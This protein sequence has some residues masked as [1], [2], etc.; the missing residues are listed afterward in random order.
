MLA[1]LSILLFLGAGVGCASTAP[2]PQTGVTGISSPGYWLARADASEARGDLAEAGRC[3]DRQVQEH[4][5]AADAELWRRRLGLALALGDVEA[6]RATRERLF[7]LAPEDEVLRLALAEDFASCERMVEA[8]AMLDHEFTDPLAQLRAWRLGAE[9]LEK[10]ELWR[11]AAELLERAAEH[12]AAGSSAGA[13]WERASWLRERAG[14]RAQAAVDLARALDG[15]E[16]GPREAAALSR[17][18]A[19]ELGEI[20][21]RVD[22]V[23]VLR[24]HTVAEHRLTAARFLAGQRFDDEI[25]V[26]ARAL[27]DPDERI[28]CIALAELAARF[29]PLER[30]FVATR[31][32]GLVEDSRLEVRL[33]ALALLGSSGARSDVVLLLAAL[34]SEEGAEFRSARRALEGLTRH[35]EPGPLDPSAEERI[36]LRQAWAAWW[37]AQPR[38]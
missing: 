19:F 1:R 35:T 6:V 20:H 38:S 10:S 22:A 14:D 27:S 26:F 24:F 34:Q 9:F 25:A 37:N 31:A 36:L 29:T 13:W 3:L 12:P 21:E 8:A 2:D 33:Q 16:L 32:R 23:A 7:S 15:V 18:R 5:D 4:P 28:V 11:E 30:D 17:L